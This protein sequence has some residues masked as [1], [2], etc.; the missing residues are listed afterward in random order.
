M[1]I[2]MW[3]LQG[4]LAFFCITGGGYKAFK[5]ADLVKRTRAFSN[6]AWTAVGALEVL[7][8]IL[9]ILPAA[10]GW[11]PQLTPIGAVVLALESLL[12]S[13]VYARVSTKAVAANPLV[14]SV[15]M[16]VMAV[17]VAWGRY[18]V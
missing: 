10:T 13:A 18:S 15:P 12:I 4:V 5:P 16:A 1:N 2:L 3:V 7:C 11:M 8:G 9:L 6:A 14:W 17:V